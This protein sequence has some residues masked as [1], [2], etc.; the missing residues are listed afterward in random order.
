VNLFVPGQTKLT[1]QDAFLGGPGTGVTDDMIGKATRIYGNTASD[2]AK[3]LAS[4]NNSQASTIRSAQA[5]AGSNIYGLQADINANP[6]RNINL[7]TPGKTQLTAQDIFLGGQGTGVGD[8]QL[9]GATRLFGNSASDTSKSLDNYNQDL[10]SQIRAAQ[11]TNAAPR[12]DANLGMATLARQQME[13]SQAQNAVSNNLARDTYNHG[14]SQDN[15]TNEYNVGNLM[16]NYKGNATMAQNQNNFSNGIAVGDLM[17]SYGGKDTLASKAQ[18]IQNAQYNAGLNQDESQFGRTL[19]SNN[20]NS[21]ANRQIDQQ[22][23]NTNATK[24]TS[25]GT[26]PTQSDIV[27]AATSKAQDYL[28]AWASGTARDDNGNLK[29]RA[30]SDEIQQWVK[31]NAGE[32][33]ASKVNVSTFGKWAADT[34]QWNP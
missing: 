24:A 11:A 6:S 34:F 32:L 7:Y 1:A 12:V 18:S 13:N 27:A 4:Y 31:D 20:S 19:A 23:A 8:D 5:G 33:T 10:S 21:A 14:V 9:H 25:A 15:F 22:N 16:G 28:N 2:T 29:P 17:G 30:T 3:G 26:N